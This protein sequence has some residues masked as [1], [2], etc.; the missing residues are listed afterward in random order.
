MQPQHPVSTDIVLI[1]AGHAH[2]EVLRR[3]AMRPM[4]GVRLTLI[5]RE[6]QAPYS[7]M[8]PGLIRGDYDFDA[9]HI[10]CA[11]L[12]AAARARLLIAEATAID[13]DTRAVAIPGRPEVAFD[14]LSVDIG[15]RLEVPPGAIAV[16]PIG[17]FLAQLAELEQRLPEG[18]RIAV[19]G[20][21]A[22]GTELALALA[23]RFGRRARISLV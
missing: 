18:G 4:P 6:P 8:L 22:G 11:P 13:L 2:V 21:G 9:A 5:A 16:K 3:A 12:A 23:H 17:R 10:D 20:G 14:L 19:I 1:G 7:G 15:G